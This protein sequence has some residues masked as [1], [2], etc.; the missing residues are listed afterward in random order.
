V[1][2][3]D[4]VGPTGAG[5][6]E[7]GGAPA[8]VQSAREAGAWGV[9]GAE[10]SGGGGAGLMRETK[11]LRFEEQAGGMSNVQIVCPECGSEYGHIREVF[12]RMGEDAAEAV[13]YKGTVARG[14]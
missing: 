11:W 1:D 6:R 3:G 8:A 10:V 5:E 2:G 13:V 12:T 7:A 4:A 14:T 9:S